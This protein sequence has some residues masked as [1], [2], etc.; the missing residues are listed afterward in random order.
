[1][2]YLCTKYILLYFI[3]YFILCVLF[4]G[5]YGDYETNLS[6]EVCFQ[7]FRNHGSL[8]HHMEVHKGITT[9]KLCG[10]VQS[11]VANL[12][13]HLANVHKVDMQLMPLSNQTFY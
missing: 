6:C 4:I 3:V 8:T 5:Y 7:T 9:C 2:I 11:R 10:K 1:M 12:K 13:R